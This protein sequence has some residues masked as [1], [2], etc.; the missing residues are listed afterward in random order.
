[1]KPRPISNILTGCP[2]GKISITMSE[3]E[4]LE[5]GMYCR[6]CHYDLRK[7]TSRRCPECGRWFDPDNA[8]TYSRQS[9]PTPVLDMVGRVGDTLERLMTEP[10]APD[11]VTRWLRNMQSASLAREVERLLR[12]NQ[13]LRAQFDCIIAIL[14]AR[15]QLDPEMIQQVHDAA[16]RAAAQPIEFVQ[17]EPPPPV[18][19]DYAAEEPTPELLELQR[20]AAERESRG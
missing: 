16:E 2:D 11:P 3:S 9:R 7:L 18:P 12:E 19:L 17:P 10:H 5:S 14:D 1:M 4:P 20:A 8:K 15:Q 13:V 6:G